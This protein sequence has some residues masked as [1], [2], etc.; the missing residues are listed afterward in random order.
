MEKLQRCFS[1][2]FDRG[3]KV[4]M[5]MDT[6]SRIPLNEYL[7]KMMI[8]YTFYNCLWFSPPSHMLTFYS[9][10]LFFLCVVVKDRPPKALSL[11]SYK[12]IWFGKERS[13]WLSAELGYLTCYFSGWIFGVYEGFCTVSLK[14][15]QYRLQK[16]E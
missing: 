6:C 4:K 3:W 16:G 2:L 5:F 1:S 7:R 11:Q 8:S 13:A 15:C 14:K 9:L 10:N 12:A